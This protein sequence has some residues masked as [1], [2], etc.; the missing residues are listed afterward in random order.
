M[1]IPKQ[2][3]KKFEARA[4]K[5]LLVGY[6]G[7][8]ANYRLYDP[9]TKR[10]S[11]SRDVTFHEQLNKTVLPTS[12]SVQ[13]EVKFKKIENEDAQQDVEKDEEDETFQSAEEESKKSSQRKVRNQPYRSTYCEI[14]QLLSDL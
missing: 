4:K 13:H 1:H 8:S 6:Q 2:F 14:V 10:V 5:M 9:V 11:I 7:D 12:D 3:I